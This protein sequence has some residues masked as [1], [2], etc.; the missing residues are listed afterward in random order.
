[1]IPTVEQLASDVLPVRFGEIVNPPAVTNFLGTVQADVDPTSIRGRNFP[2]LF[3]AD[4]ATG[5]LFLDGEYVIGTGATI[6]MV[7]R[8]DRIERRLHFGDYELT[9]LTTAPVGETAIAQRLLVSNLGPAR[10]ATLRFAVTG[11]VTRFVGTIEGAAPPGAFT[12]AEVDAGRGA[13]VFTDPETG[14]TSVQGVAPVATE[15]DPASLTVRINLEARE[16]RAVDFVEA[17]GETVQEALAAYDRIIGDV[18]GALDAAEADWNEELRAIVTPGNDRYSGHLPVLETS[19]ADLQRLYW[20]GIL[21]VVS[22]KRESPRSVLGRTYDT[23]MPRYW[24]TVTFLWDYSLSSTVHALLDPEVM[25]RQQNHW[26]TTDIH[27]CMG[28]EWLTGAGL[29]AWYAVNDFAMTRLMSDYVRWTGDASWLDEPVEGREDGV[30]RIDEMVT[31]ARNWQDFATPNGLADYGG[32]GNLL[33]CVSTYIHEVASL[34]AASVYSL[35]TTAELMDLRGDRAQ[36]EQLRKE[37][38]ELVA[39]VQE[40]YVE[41][42]GFW[43]A[44]FP[45]GSLVPVRHCYDLATVLYAIPDD[46][47]ASQRDEMVSFF[48]RELQTPTWMRAL[49]NRD[50]DAVFSVRADHQW[51]GAYCAWPS[52]IAAGLYGIG[53]GQRAAAWLRG[54]AKSANQGPF[55]Q[56]H[57]IDSVIDAHAGGARKVPAEMPYINDWAC[58]SGGSWTRLIIEGVF[59]VRAGL[60]EITAA[61]DLTGFDPDA[62]LVGLTW[63]GREHVVDRNG[64]RALD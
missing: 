47:S 30:R 18:G 48:E 42:Q 13:V 16:R 63:Q 38:G 15:L 57:F 55:G 34:N 11:W 17:F 39:R 24:P 54:L 58:S 2:P 9:C 52:E 7:W 31:Y 41:G 22:F 43:N 45:D 46:L 8:P 37:A 62:R 56:A 21:G 53:E 5:Q 59:G 10:D 35:R 36:A 40:L 3:T 28:T 25:Q 19:D 26:M 49:S 27:T 23:L 1:M 51:N 12:T 33:E 61:P 64:I 32:I 60:D 44:R 6:D 20:M 4:T 50:H 29:G 14:A